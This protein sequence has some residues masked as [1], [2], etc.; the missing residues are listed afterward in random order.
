MAEDKGVLRGLT[1]LPREASLFPSEL[2]RP[3][4]GVGRRPHGEG[5][6]V[7]AY[8]LEA[9]VCPHLSEGLCEIYADRPSSCR[10]FPFSLEPGRDGPVVGLDMNCPGASA[11]LSGGGRVDAGDLVSAEALYRLKL[12]V[13]GSPRRSWFY[14]LRNGEWV[15]ADTLV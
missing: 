13:A 4:V 3:A 2:V 9:D 7:V 15:R 12:Q 1:L 14:D 5:F 6:R 8:Q 10:Q 11:L